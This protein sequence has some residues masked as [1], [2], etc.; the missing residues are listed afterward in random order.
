MPK[1]IAIGHRIDALNNKHADVPGTEPVIDFSEAGLIPN[2]SNN[3]SY[4][5]DLTDRVESAGSNPVGKYGVVRNTYSG[6]FSWIG[7][8]YYRLYKISVQFL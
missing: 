2:K 6:R 3:M 5:L 7:P 8:N 1:A 4:S